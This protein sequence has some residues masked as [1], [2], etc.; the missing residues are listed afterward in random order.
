MG[1]GEGNNSNIRF[2]L[3]K[4]ITIKYKFVIRASI[5]S[6]L[7]A[8]LV[9]CGASLR[10][11]KK[12]ANAGQEYATALDT[13]LVTS[14]NY[15]VDA[16][17][18]KLLSNRVEDTVKDREEMYIEITKQDKQWL[19]LIGRMRQ[20]TDLLKRYFI[21]LENLATSDA[22]TQAQEVTEDIFT[23]L[24]NVSANIQGNPLVSDGTGSALSEIP[25]IILSNKIT[26]ALRKEL[27]QR[28]ETIYR[29]LAIQELVLELLTTEL[30]NDLKSIQTNQEERLLFRPYTAADPISDA[31]A[32]IERRR[33][34][35]TMTLSIEALNNASE[36]AKDFKEA[37]QLLLEDKFTIAR[38]NELLSEINS[39]VNIAEEI[40]NN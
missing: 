24:N 17:S 21:A 3:R 39:L 15:A 6:F 11:Y 12:F 9:A 4:E 40:K 34:I 36:S 20:H 38:A 22:P 1:S 5:I 16:S 33:N 18:E 2:M 8:S 28:K 13:L 35:L 32:W 7:G 25:K 26:G 19:M 29:E 30:K 27:E 10:E 23:Q 14:G 37:F 31:D